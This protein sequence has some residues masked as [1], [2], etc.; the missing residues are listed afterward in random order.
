M[1]NGMLFVDELTEKRRV[2][3]HSV[4]ELRVLYR[5]VRDFKRLVEDAKRMDQ[6]T[7]ETTYTQ[8]GHRRF[9]ELRRLFHTINERLAALDSDEIRRSRNWILENFS[10]ALTVQRKDRLQ[11]KMGS[12]IASLSC[13]LDEIQAIGVDIQ[14]KEV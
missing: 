10:N 2:R 4:E 1:S 3:E 8:F 5:D 12:T 9:Q 11:G 7:A 14:I 6:R 13:I